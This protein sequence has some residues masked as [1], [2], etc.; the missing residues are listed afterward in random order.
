MIRIFKRIGLTFATACVC[1]SLGGC[2]VS[3]KEVQTEVPVVEPA[4]P[5]ATSSTTTTTTRTD[6]GAVQREHST[7]TYTAP[8]Q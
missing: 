4:P 8:I 6:D 2:F 7:T 1:A 5:L 3:H